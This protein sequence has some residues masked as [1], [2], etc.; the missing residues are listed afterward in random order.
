MR[1]ILLAGLGLAL[2]AGG[3]EA[4]IAQ[5][6]T[7]HGT[8]RIEGTTRYPEVER[9]MV[10]DKVVVEPDPDSAQQR[11]W[12]AA[13]LGDVLLVGLGSTGNG[14][15][16]GYVF[17]HTAAGE[18]LRTSD[19][20]GTCGGDLLATV[21]GKTIR[22]SMDSMNPNEGRL[23]YVYD[24]QKIA[25]RVMGQ[26]ESHSPPTASARNWIGRYPGEL[27][28]YADWHEPL[29]SLMGEEAYKEAQQVLDLSDDDGMQ[30]SGGWISGIAFGHHES[31]GSWGAVAINED[32]RRLLV[33]LGREGEAPRMWGDAGGPLSLPI[34]EALRKDF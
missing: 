33:V 20:F 26:Q 24:G 23:E 6:V 8:A 25:E 7:P 5:V 17:V 10:G 22:V 16:N 12:I 18:D 31:T 3:A 1:H 27:F 32:D 13:K 4:Q 15:Y 30:L 19:Q 29:V 34:L 9:L 2:L 11:V 21:E 28:K 14:C